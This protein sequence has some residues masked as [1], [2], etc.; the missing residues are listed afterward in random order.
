MKKKGWL[1]EKQIRRQKEMLIGRVTAKIFAHTVTH[2]GH[3]CNIPCGDIRIKNIGL[4][5]HCKNQPPRNKTTKR[6]KN[7][8]ENISP[9]VHT[10]E[11][12][13]KACCKTLKID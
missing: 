6:N 3:S 7:E 10:K 13:K 12:E 2:V 11:K 5:K 4:P 1:Q 9:D 8:E